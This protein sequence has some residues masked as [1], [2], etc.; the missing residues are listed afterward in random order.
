MV[1]EINA[2]RK[3]ITAIIMTLA[4]TLS[5]TGFAFVDAFADE[6]LGTGDQ[7]QQLQDVDGGMDDQGKQD[8]AGELA[9]EDGTEALTEG[10]Q[11]ADGT[12]ESDEE[13]ALPVLTEMSAEDGEEPSEPEEPE[14]PPVPGPVTFDENSVR[15]LSDMTVK[16]GNLGINLRFMLGEPA[17]GYSVVQG[18]CTDGTYAY[19]LM[20]KSSNQ[21]GKVLKVKLGSNEVVKKSKVIDI[22]HGNGMAYDSKNHRLV[23]VGREERRNQITLINAEDLTFQGYVN[24]DFNTASA[25]NWPV[26]YGGQRAGLAAISYVEKYDCY[27][28]LQRKTHDIL[29]LDQNFRVIGFICTQITARYPGTY[30]AMDA[31]ERYIYLLLSYYSGY[32]PKNRIVALDWNS[33]NMLDYVNHP[34]SR[35]SFAKKWS[36]GNGNNG[37]PDADVIINT[38]YEAENIFHFRDASG[39]TVFYLS[40][41][42]YNPQY[43]WVN[44]K[45]TYKV[46]WKKVK[47]KVKV[48]WKRVKKKNGKYKWKYKYKYKK[49]WKY[50]KKH[51]YVKVKVLSYYDRHDYVYKL[52]GM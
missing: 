5:M 37:M 10:K 39:N 52:N 49:V 19:Y 20:V 18:G 51:K 23:V 29:V 34:E 31:D 8:A 14:E 21:Q 12:E 30:Q 6:E 9:D 40:E 1:M 45:V 32:Q 4:M 46:K 41:Y 33:E 27:V 48:K 24:V 2:I 13:E 38:P 47:K 43:K 16:A 35:A 7:T 17:G 50:K 22:C 25:Q 15:A 28:A 36:C 11:Q 42:N 44:K 26:N 3:R